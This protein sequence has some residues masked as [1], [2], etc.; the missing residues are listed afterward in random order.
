MQAR[1]TIS[2]SAVEALTRLLAFRRSPIQ[3]VVLSMCTQVWRFIQVEYKSIP[4][5]TTGFVAVR[6]F[7]TIIT[8]MF[9]FTVTV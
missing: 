4:A 2:A 9:M 3:G 6:S 1:N 5:A 7:R 8:S